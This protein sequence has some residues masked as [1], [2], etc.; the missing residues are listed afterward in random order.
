MKKIITLILIFGITIVNAQNA[1]D[2]QFTANAG[3][4]LQPDGSGGYTGT[5]C[6]TTINNGFTLT[7]QNVPANTY[8]FNGYNIPSGVN[9]NPTT[10]VITVNNANIGTYDFEVTWKIKGRAWNKNAPDNKVK[11]INIEVKEKPSA[12]TN[13]SDVSFCDLPNKWISDMCKPLTGR[14]NYEYQI[15][16]DN[17][18]DPTNNGTHPSENSSAWGTTR[19][20]HNQ[21]ISKKYGKHWVRAR[22]KN[23]V[24]VSDWAYGSITYKRK[25]EDLN[26]IV[27]YGGFTISNGKGTFCKTAGNT[28]FT[29]KAS[30]YSGYK[31]K[32]FEGNTPLGNGGHNDWAVI[33]DPSLGE[34]TYK[35]QVAKSTD[36]NWQCIKEVEVKIS[37]QSKLTPPTVNNV[38]SCASA[39]WAHDITGAKHFETK[40]DN[41]PEYKYQLKNGNDWSNPTDVNYNYYMAGGTPKTYT[42]RARA[43]KAGYCPSD[44]S[45]E[46]TVTIKEKPQDLTFDI[47]AC[48]TLTD[49]N[50]TLEGSMCKNSICNGGNNTGFTLKP[51]NVPNGYSFKY[52][53]SGNEISTNTN[54]IQYPTVGLHTYIVKW[55]K[56]NN[57]DCT[58]QK[59]IKID[60]KELPKPTPTSPQYLCNQGQNWIGN[61]VYTGNNE[62]Q[63]N[64]DYDRFVLQK[65]DGSWDYG[66]VKNYKDLIWAET[67]N[68]YNERSAYKRQPYF[69][70]LKKGNGNCNSKWSDPIEVY[71]I[72]KG[73][74]AP[75]VS[76][77]WICVTNEM[78]L[79]IKNPLSYVRY[80]WSKKGSN[81]AITDLTDAQVDAI[82]V[83]GTSAHIIVPSEENV[84][85]KVRAV[86][87]NS[88]K[89]RCESP[90]W[91]NYYNTKITSQVDCGDTGK[92][93]IF[94]IDNK[95][96][97]KFVN[98]VTQGGTWDGDF[99]H[100]PSENPDPVTGDI[101]FHPNA[102]NPIKIIIRDNNRWHELVFQSDVDYTN[103]VDT[104]HKIGY[105]L[106]SNGDKTD[107]YETLTEVM[108][109]PAVSGMTGRKIASYTNESGGIEEIKETI[110]TLTENNNIYTYK[111]EN[112]TPT[113]IDLNNA[114]DDITTSGTH[115]I[116]T[117]TYVDGTK[118]PIKETA[119]TFQDVNRVTKKRSVASYK[120]EA[121]GNEDQ[122]NETVTKII[123]DSHHNTDV[124]KY[125]IKVAVPNT[126]N[127]ED[128]QIESSR[129]I[130]TY[131]NEELP[132][133]PKN[134]RETVTSIE[135]AIPH[136]SNPY[137]FTKINS[138]NKKSKV[139]ASLNIGR[140]KNENLDKY[141]NIKETITM[142]QPQ[143]PYNYDNHNESQNIARYRPEQLN[144][145]NNN[146][147]SRNIRETIT[148]MEQN[149]PLEIVEYDKPVPGRP[150][151]SYGDIKFYNEE[152]PY[153]TN[154]KK[155]KIIRVV[156]KFKGNQLKIGR[157]GG[158]YARRLIWAGEI[159]AYTG[160]IVNST[161]GVDSSLANCVTNTN[162]IGQSNNMDCTID[163]SHPALGTSLGDGI[164]SIIYKVK[165]NPPLKSNEYVVL[166]TAENIYLDKVGTGVHTT[167][168]LNYYEKE[169]DGFTF[170]LFNKAGGPPSL[171]YRKKIKEKNM[172]IYFMVIGY[173]NVA[174]D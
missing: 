82:A 108:P 101:H 30:K 31:F 161:P 59:T 50:G 65:A 37:V 145:D 68:R 51:Q 167:P 121:E 64:F 154:Q 2:L 1:Q 24:C 52:Y 127:S 120:K 53:E 123:Q 11:G 106:K 174:P 112:G 70:R 143:L 40:G 131:T 41:T 117:V 118:K 104:K 29:I 80:Q 3:I 38:V 33:Q 74:P 173:G 141:V 115:T 129:V 12:P 57:W 9:I 122:I 54:L 98:K 105:F 35:M 135:Q 60:V 76:T 160:R 99:T 88:N 58:N 67:H 136:N 25:P 109:K 169:K 152:T 79:S 148:K 172:S 47:N 7:P 44:W 95:G 20:N 83:G 158:M 81:G 10:G 6:K 89:G 49:N 13:I 125:T 93:G 21:V 91:S 36:T 77:N 102:V 149:R 94:A 23:G 92:K 71:V 132:T 114:I 39:K 157:D 32:F 155:P 34:H 128:K 61:I 126:N 150:D 56:D 69:I 62:T 27:Q 43:E 72:D 124:K 90:N 26:I 151:E 110:T 42:F 137:K 140:Y 8:E 130:A 107:V 5:M 138:N 100:N 4:N 63:T 45:G 73:A 156:S 18:E 111:S 164:K 15:I 48:I 55:A 133:D 134:I 78:D 142:L 22:A 119:T 14:E 103:L 171:N 163:T 66:D 139:W 16:Y 147:Y 17:D 96:T 86:V 166:L 28:G 85:Y 170:A 146:D 159:N 144:G 19:Y 116:A 75:E 113:E 46:A 97:I 84:Q 162:G 153:E 165:F 168:S 87:P